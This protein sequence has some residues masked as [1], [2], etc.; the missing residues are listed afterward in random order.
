M[1]VEQAIL[2]GIAHRAINSLFSHINANND[3]SKYFSAVS[4]F[5]VIASFEHDMHLRRAST[6]TNQI[7][8][9]VYCNRSSQL[10]E[11]RVLLNSDS[12]MTFEKC[13]FKK[14][15]DQF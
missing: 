3:N 5:V 1:N 15:V 12:S 8:A 7:N 14:S 6:L 9:L 10:H 2:E 13:V 11:I 4:C